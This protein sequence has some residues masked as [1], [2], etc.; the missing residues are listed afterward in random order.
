MHLKT[1]KEK[2]FTQDEIDET[3]WTGTS[4]AGSPVMVFYEQFKNAY[5]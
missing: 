1:A 5:R 2:G 3:E 4:F